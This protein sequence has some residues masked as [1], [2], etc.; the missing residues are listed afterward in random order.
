MSVHQNIFQALAFWTDYEINLPLGNTL[1]PTLLVIFVV[2]YT[3]DWDHLHFF[4]KLNSCDIFVIFIC[5]ETY[6]PF[7]SLK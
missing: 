7:E 6:K 5:R 2:F 3:R 4:Q 1:Q